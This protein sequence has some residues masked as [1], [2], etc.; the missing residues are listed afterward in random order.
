MRARGDW[1][2]LRTL[3]VLR[4][5]AITGQA[6]TVL[7]ATQVLNF[8]LPLSLCAA[9]ISA[10]VSFNVI[11][12]IVHP[13]EKRLSERGTLFSLFFDLVQLVTMLLLTGGLNNPFAVLIIAPVT[14]AA[15][16]LRLQSTLALGLSALG[17]IP[18][19]AT[20]H[21]PLIQ[22]DGV[23][24]VIPGLFRYGIAA[25]LVI[26][27]VF[28]G[29]YAR[30]VTVEAFAMSEALSATQIALAREQRLAAIGGI[31]AATAHEL[32]TPLATIKLVAGEL[33]HEAEDHP[34]LAE[35]LALIR[36]EADRCG[37]ILADLSQGGRDDSH[38]KFAPISSVIDE[39]AGPHV[40]RGKDLV[41][42]IDGDL[43]ELAGERNHRSCVALN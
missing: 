10:S 41:V 22:P 2:R 8:D 29:V 30:R 24:L 33:S 11:A 35:D 36:S 31:A 23:E 1:V 12:H 26:G 21:L 42:R 17:S 19:L 16:A 25:A 3:V 32:G 38:V 40:K 18:L 20:V 7:I 28:L 13:A 15:T 4:W 34:E 14:I 6:A 39:A 43:A 37:A 9:V 27:L 5:M